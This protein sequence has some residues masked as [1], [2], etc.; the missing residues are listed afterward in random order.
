MVQTARDAEHGLRP[1]ATHRPDAILLDLRMP[2]VDGLGFPRL[3]CAD[4]RYVAIAL[5]IRDARSLEQ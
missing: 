2:L 4:G 5:G 1:A 3:L